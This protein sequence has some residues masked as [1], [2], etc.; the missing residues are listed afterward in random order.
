MLRAPQ[1]MLRAPQWMLRVPQWMLRAPQW[2]LRARRTVFI[3]GAF[4]TAPATKTGR[5]SRG[6]RRSYKSQGG[7][8]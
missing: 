2:M 5:G 8:G 6:G 3:V 7:G 1:W 4:F